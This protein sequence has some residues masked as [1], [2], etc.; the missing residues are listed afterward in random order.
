MLTRVTNNNN[1]GLLF[2]SWD[3]Q[4]RTM[5]HPMTGLVAIMASKVVVMSA[6]PS[7]FVL[8]VYFICATWSL[9]PLS[10]ATHCFSLEL[11]KEFPIIW[12]FPGHGLLRHGE[13]LKALRPALTLANLGSSI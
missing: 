8:V 12:Q 11:P 4:L 2:Y 3:G 13:T 5:W 1:V 6:I 9:G 10:W 7:L